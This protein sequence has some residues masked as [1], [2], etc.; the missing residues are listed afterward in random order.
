VLVQ[1]FL[2]MSLLETESR[3]GKSSPEFIKYHPF[4]TYS[5][6]PFYPIIPQTERKHPL[7][8]FFYILYY[9]NKT[10]EVAVQNGD[11]GESIGIKH[12]DHT[13]PALP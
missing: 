5:T 6:A 7:K 11:E 4:D 2:D 8:S 1:Y 10:R 3:D 9:L 12:H 13:G